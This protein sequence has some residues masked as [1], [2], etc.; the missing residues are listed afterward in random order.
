MLLF[1][2]VQLKEFFVQSY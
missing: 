2:N 1:K